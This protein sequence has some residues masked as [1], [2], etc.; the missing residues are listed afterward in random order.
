MRLSDPA[1][2]AVLFPFPFH[3]DHE[4]LYL[5]WV[6]FRPSHGDYRDVAGIKVPFTWTASQT[7]MQMTVKLPDITPNVPVDAARFLK[8]PP[9]MAKR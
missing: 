9:G 8:P 6:P 5:R 1:P 3:V 2:S 4:R 7:Y